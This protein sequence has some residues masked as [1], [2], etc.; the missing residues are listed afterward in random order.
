MK[1]P[2]KSILFFKSFSKIPLQ[3]ISTKVSGRLK[4]TNKEIKNRK[5]RLICKVDGGQLSA[6][7]FTSQIY[8]YSAVSVSGIIQ[9]VVVL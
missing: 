8:V 4:F 9:L 6:L 5:A 3:H 7:L 2:V 1:V